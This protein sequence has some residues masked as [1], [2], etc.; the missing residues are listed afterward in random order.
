MNSNLQDG[1]IQ[2][3]GCDFVFPFV[4]P[5]CSR[6]GHYIGGPTL[7]RRARWC[8]TCRALWTSQHVAWLARLIDGAG[9]ALWQIPQLPMAEWP[10]TRRAIIWRAAKTGRPANYFAAAADLWGH[11]ELTVLLTVSG[12]HPAISDS[13]QAIKNHSAIVVE[14]AAKLG[15][16]LI[17]S[18]NWTMPSAVG[19]QIERAAA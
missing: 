5:H 10:K 8:K 19:Q 18:K 6:L 3:T 7:P 1:A 17:Y 16:R 2:V 14:R 12:A 4:G 11:D 15:R 9:S 13:G